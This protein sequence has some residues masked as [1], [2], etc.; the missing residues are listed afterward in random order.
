MN[1]KEDAK[2][3][4]IEKV[5]KI[6]KRNTRNKNQGGFMN[7]ISTN[8][9]VEN[10]FGDET[11]E[12]E[13]ATRPIIDQK[14]FHESTTLQIEIF[15]EN[16]GSINA[17]EEDKSIG[18]EIIHSIG[19]RF[20]DNVDKRHA[21][22]RPKRARS[23][24]MVLDR[25]DILDSRAKRFHGDKGCDKKESYFPTSTDEKL[26]RN[27]IHSSMEDIVHRQ[28]IR[29]HDVEN[30]QCNKSNMDQ[31][32]EEQER[33]NRNHHG[34]SHLEHERKNRA[35]Y[36]R[37]DAEQER[38]DRIN[39]GKQDLEQERGDRI[40]HGKQDLGQERASRTHHRR[41]EN[42]KRERS[43][44]D[45]F[46]MAREL[47]IRNN[48]RYGESRRNYN[49]RD[50]NPE[51]RRLTCLR[52][53]SP[54]SRRLNGSQDLEYE[55]RRLSGPRDLE[56]E[57]RRLGGPQDLELEPRRL[58]GP[59]DLELELRQLGGPRDLEL[60][61][62]RL[63]GPR[64]LELES[65]RLGGSRDF[66]LESRQSSGLR[67][68][69]CELKCFKSPQDLSPKSRRLTRSRDMNDQQRLDAYDQYS[70]KNYN[71]DDIRRSPEKS[72]GIGILK[73][74]CPEE[75]QK[76]IAFPKWFT[77]QSNTCSL[78]RIEGNRSLN[79]PLDL[80]GESFGRENFKFPSFHGN[81]G[82]HDF[83]IH[84][85][86][87]GTDYSDLSKVNYTDLHSSNLRH[88]IDYS[89][90]QEVT[91]TQRNKYETYGLH[92]SSSDLNCFDTQTK[93]YSNQTFGMDNLHSLNQLDGGIG[94]DYGIN[95][96]HRGS[97]I[98]SDMPNLSKDIREDPWNYLSPNNNLLT[99]YRND[100]SHTPLIKSHDYTPSWNNI[101]PSSPPS[102][103]IRHSTFE[104][105]HISSLGSSWNQPSLYPLPSTN[106][107]PF[108]QQEPW[109]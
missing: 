4:N 3:C 88:Q 45:E 58:G 57:P 69:E 27:N 91:Y 53:L 102:S 17:G 11:L 64:D 90:P 104:N 32:D 85:Q 46:S 18:E 6:E 94:R 70:M 29:K 86:T 48:L 59:R 71:D 33:T 22:S 84:S 14:S 77:A 109:S 41:Q 47:N 39:H 101:A 107:M 65:R 92:N 108:P 93:T 28:R 51:S 38:G 8:E 98:G 30:S 2:D 35:H 106:L 79:L 76:G 37:R 20:E 50:I 54:R 56:L 25:R 97:L 16:K 83:P 80:G 31:E 24:D 95:D 19:T 74:Q 5:N 75:E 63:G 100:I 21:I 68:S 60:E 34:R 36:E 103:Y 62:R 78:G 44:K 73:V 42:D 72:R 40:N 96:F 1:T 15:K 12:I 81:H 52:D 10:P 87:Y 13:K 7:K 99:S 26:A 55:P 66:E 82:F 23:P 49:F 9:H 61:P 105:P 89:N 67:D 43:K